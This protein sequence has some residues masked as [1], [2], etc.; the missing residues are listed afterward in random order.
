VKF[1][2]HAVRLCQ[3]RHI[4]STIEIAD[5]GLDYVDYQDE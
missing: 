4:G 1:G 3:A 2:Q 5:A